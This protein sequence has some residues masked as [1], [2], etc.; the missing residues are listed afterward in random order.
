MSQKSVSLR[1]GYPVSVIGNVGRTAQVRGGPAMAQDPF[2]IPVGMQRGCR[3]FERWR[4]GQGPLADPGG[5]VGSSGGSGSGARGFPR[6]QGPATGVR[7]AQADGGSRCRGG[8]ADDGADNI[9]GTDA[10][11]GR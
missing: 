3:R 8:A 7:Q 6:L 1:Q 9:F 11:P 10:A 5:V 2:E 4:K